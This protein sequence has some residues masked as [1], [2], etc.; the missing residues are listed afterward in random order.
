MRLSKRIYAL[1]DCVIKGH[2]AADIGTDHGYVP[3]LLI[4]NGISPRVIMSDISEGSLA[5]AKET[6]RQCGLMD[7]VSE[8]DFRTGYGLETIRPGEVDAVIIAGLGGHTIADILTADIRKSMSFKNLILQPR[9]HSGNL[10]CALYTNGWDIS[11][12]ILVPEGKFVCEIICAVPGRDTEPGMIREAPYPEEDIR[13]K[14]PEAIV[15][16]DRELAA[17]RIAWKTDSIKEEIENLKHSSHDRDALIR[18][19]EADRDYL[20]GLIKGD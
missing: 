12:E 17:R 10:R 16:A 11:D 14:Y 7:K 20:E 4:R 15:E 9:K 2:S 8:S 1:A 18:Q 3:M 19:L 6:F 13:W 5:K